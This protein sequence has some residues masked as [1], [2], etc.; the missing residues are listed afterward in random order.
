LLLEQDLL[1]RFGSDQAEEKQSP[2]R[3]KK[4]ALLQ[5]RGIAI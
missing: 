5:K 3:K 2:S 4:S 1:L